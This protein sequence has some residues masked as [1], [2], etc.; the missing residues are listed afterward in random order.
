MIS[1]LLKNAKE[2]RRIKN[3]LKPKL[4]KL[5]TQHKDL[6]EYYKYSIISIFFIFYW[7]YWN[8]V[9]IYLG[10]FEK[11]PEAGLDGTL[12]FD[13]DC[14]VDWPN[15]I[16]FSLCLEKRGK[17][18]I[19]EIQNKIL[20]LIVG[21]FAMQRKF[22]FDESFDW[23]DSSKFGKRCDD[24]RN[25]SWKILEWNSNCPEFLIQLA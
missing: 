13:L 16:F 25:L 22:H 12:S 9:A 23:K 5:I 24:W 4:I 14:S 6:K 20:W 10:P 21:M 11:F 8:L 17:I 1:I 7:F 3:V 15:P 19:Y 18:V 2:W